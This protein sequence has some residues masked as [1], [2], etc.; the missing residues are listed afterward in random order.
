MEQLTEF[1][2]KSFDRAVVDGAAATRE[3]SAVLQSQSLKQESEPD[4]DCVEE[5]DEEE[6]QEQP[7]DMRTAVTPDSSSPTLKPDETE[8]RILITIHRSC[9]PLPQCGGS[10][11]RNILVLWSVKRPKIVIW[12][13]EAPKDWEA[14]HK[15]CMDSGHA[16]AFEISAR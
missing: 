2:S 1:V 7:V 11:V 13:S 8:G 12:K 14:G 5:E 16:I 15:N 10:C 6:D 4:E 3:D 9:Y